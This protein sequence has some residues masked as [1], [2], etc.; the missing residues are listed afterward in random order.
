M[1]LTI[2]QSGESTWAL[3]VGASLSIELGE[4]H[5]SVIQFIRDWYHEHQATPD[6]RLA[7]RQIEQLAKVDGRQRMFQPLPYGYVAKACKI[8]GI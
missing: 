5:G 7:I 4:A 6:T 3:Q 8:A 1:P 2:P